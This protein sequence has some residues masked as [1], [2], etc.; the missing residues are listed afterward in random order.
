MSSSNHQKDGSKNLLYVSLCYWLFALSDGALRMLVLLHLHEQ[1]QTAWGLTLALLPYE[2]AGCA[3]NVVGGYLGSRFGLKVA[4]CI[5][6]LM[7][8]VACALLAIEQSALTI[9]YVMLTQ[10][11]SGVAKD[12][13]KTSAKSYVRAL[14]A[15]GESRGLFRLVA[16]L[17]GS[18]NSMKGLGFF[19]GGA[20]LGWVGFG[21]TN[22]C[23]ATLLAVSA[24][25]AIL[26]LPVVPGSKATTW[27]TTL[28]ADARL[29]WLS[30]SRL[31]LFGSRDAWF[32]VAL[33]LYLIAEDWSQ[34]AVGAALSLWIIGYGIMQAT[35]PRFSKVATTPH[36]AKSI[37]IWTAALALPLI[38]TAW[39]IPTADSNL[40]LLWS[41]LAA[42]GVLF[43]VISSLHSWLV[44]ALYS[45]HRVAA[46]VGFYYAANA[47]GR[48]VGLVASGWLYANADSPEDGLIDSMIAAAL[49][50]IIAAI[51]SFQLKRILDRSGAANEVLAADETVTKSD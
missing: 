36:G 41:G 14:T 50:T 42:Y 18:K 51:C 25:G 44:V 16:A 1:G 21:V 3:T 7:Q 47:L 13:V 24:I 39:L 37:T 40:V 45:G 10:V 38:A 33:P 11:G 48:V 5:G 29:R 43:A 15:E 31:F 27:R 26:S 30:V 2:I 23:L 49:A 46:K 22:L 28:T 4:L 9:G 12:L 8:A 17:T 34:A 6:M 32:A 19:L 35:A 20:L